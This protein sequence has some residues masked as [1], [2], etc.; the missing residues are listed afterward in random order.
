M[1]EHG[2]GAVATASEVDAA[3]VRLLRSGFTES[4]F[5]THTLVSL[6]FTPKQIRLSRERQGLLVFRRG[7]GRSM[8]SYWALPLPTYCVPRVKR[9]SWRRTQRGGAAPVATTAA[10]AHATLPAGHQ[11]DL[12]PDESA[13][14]ARRVEFFG[15]RGM[16]EAEAQGLATRLV[17]ERDRLRLHA[18]GSCIECQEAARGQCDLVQPHSVIHQCW[19]RRHDG[20]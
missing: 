18:T 2:P 5:V 4:R 11:V 14:V 1:N 10:S 6:G 17:L 7:C 12:S 13:L 9:S 16:R 8:R 15:A 20:P 3:L 19:L